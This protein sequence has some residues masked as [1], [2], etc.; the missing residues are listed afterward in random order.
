MINIRR[1]IVNLL[2]TRIL[3][4]MSAFRVKVWCRWTNIALLLFS[5]AAVRVEGEHYCR[6]KSRVWMLLLAGYSRSSGV[7]IEVA[8]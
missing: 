6:L 1:D 8:R 5:S 4:Q 2:P 7:Y 3:D